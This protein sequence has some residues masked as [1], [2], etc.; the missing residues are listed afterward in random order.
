MKTKH[1]IFFTLIA[2][3]LSALLALSVAACSGKDKATYKIVASPAD[4]C[5][6]TLSV[7]EAEAGSAVTFAVVPA[8]G[9]T[10]TGAYANGSPCA[11]GTDGSYSF[12]MPDSAVTITVTVSPLPATDDDESVNEV[13]SDGD[14]SWA[15]DAPSVLPAAKTE[16]ETA[17]YM[18]FFD[19]AESKYL[20]GS[21]NVELKSL[22]PDV[23][24]DSALGSL[25]L[26]S[27]GSGNLFKGGNFIL[28]LKQCSLG[29]AFVSLSVSGSMGGT[30]IDNTVVK[31]IR[32]V[33]F[34]EFSPE[35]WT[36]TVN[37]NIP[38]YADY[39]DLTIQVYNDNMFKYGVPSGMR[40]IPVESE[41]TT[42]EALYSP[43]GKLSVLVYYYEGDNLKYFELDNVVGEGSTET[44]EFV[45][46]DGSYAYF[47]SPGQT[48]TIDVR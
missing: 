24:P 2:V 35:L 40:Q 34:E 8:N 17:Y 19:F 31:K 20:A 13:L 10:V 42:I 16:D 27:V 9:Y 11:A 18:I 44:G 48:L 22:S 26:S 6:I 23:I 38:D 39:E 37:V 15:K 43:Y 33:P 36:V 14:L 28:D 21:Q 1:K 41:T 3:M 4:N 47:P 46:F 45:T 29:E 25:S 30:S 7:T 32:I 5:T 12:T